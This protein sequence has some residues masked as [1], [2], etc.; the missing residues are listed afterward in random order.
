MRSYLLLLVALL[1]TQSQ[2]HGQSAPVRPEVV[3]IRGVLF[4]YGTGAFT[5]DDVVERGLVNGVDKDALLL[6]VE[7][8][9]PPAGLYWAKP[10]PQYTLRLVVTELG[11]QKRVFKLARPIGFLPKNGK[12]YVLFVVYD[13]QCSHLD[14][15]AT[16]VGP[17]PKKQFQQ[18]IG[19]ACGEI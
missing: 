17:G 3:A 13:V 9:G 7:L 12:R 19:M 8:A 4:D 16:V 10:N 11:G 6:T 2:A 15:V 5:N 1:C 14:V 18:G